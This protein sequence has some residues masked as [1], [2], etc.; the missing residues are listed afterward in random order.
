M[1]EADRELGAVLHQFP[2]SEGA[3]AER[4]QGEASTSGR[5]SPNGGPEAR[6]AK[7]SRSQH[8]GRPKTRSDAKLTRLS[9]MAERLRQLQDQAAT[10]NAR[11]QAEAEGRMAALQAIAERDLI[12]ASNQQALE[13]AAIEHRY[14]LK[15]ST[16]R[17][18]IE[19]CAT[20]CKHCLS[21]TSH[22]F[23]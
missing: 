18:T 16:L 21:T 22:Y 3:A 1:A 9:E 20:L 15:A 13:A 10:L 8:D 14:H 17:Y 6:A 11:A 19:F 23:L 12:I 7:R 2:P 4:G 5:D